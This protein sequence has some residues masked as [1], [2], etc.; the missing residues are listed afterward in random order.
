MADKTS[1]KN[2]A[3]VFI[4]PHAVNDKVKG[5]VESELKKRSITITDTGSISAEAIDKGSLIDQHYYAIA[6]KAVLL[7]PKD[8]PV[9]ADKFKAK[10]GVEWSQALKDGQVFNAKAYGEKNKLNAV[11]L[12]KLWREKKKNC[13]KFGGGFYCSNLGTEKEPAYVFNGFF[14][15]LRDKFVAKGKSITWFTVEFDADKLSW[16]DFRGKV[17][18]P[19]NPADAPKDS[20]RGL[21]Y[22]DWKALGLA[23][24]PDTGDNGVHAS[25]SPFE[26][27]AERL[28]WI[29]ADFKKDAFAQALVKA[30]VSEKTIKAWCVDPQVVTEKKES[31]VVKGSI[32]DA[33]EDMDADDCLKKC[34]ELGKLNKE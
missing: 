29:K 21:I 8:L 15:S 18:G 19:T 31:E 34:E 1:M 17:L 22:A 4:K 10:F 20:V 23:A 16:E 13:V 32:F 2:S 25:A 33:L 3:F 30:G 14:M 9:P 7:E 24:E 27:L 5:L 11:D 6:S 26:G 12:E 28:N